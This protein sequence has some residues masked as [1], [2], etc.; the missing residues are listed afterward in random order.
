MG[1]Q[2]ADAE[3]VERLI[4][5][6]VADVKGII[7]VVVREAG[8]PS[9]VTQLLKRVWVVPRSRLVKFPSRRSRPSPT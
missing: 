7:V 6:N 4:A 2:E 5:G 9:A 8:D 3:L 1:D